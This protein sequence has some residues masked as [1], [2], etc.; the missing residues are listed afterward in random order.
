VNATW[1][2][3]LALSATLVVTKGIGP[4]ALGNREL[5]RAF[6]KVIDLL[7]PAILAALI[8]VGTFTD[9]DGDLVIDARAAGL[10]AA[11][12]AF[13]ASRKSLLATVAAAAITAALV[14]AVTA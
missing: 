7:A 3:I 8:A 5:P 1:T 4:V 2:T 11:G 9:S 10:V 12:F 14:R 13:Y 6:T